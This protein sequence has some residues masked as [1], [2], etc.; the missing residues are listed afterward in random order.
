[1]AVAKP[2]PNHHP[3]ETRLKPPSAKVA[4]QKKSFFWAYC[5][6][7][8]GFLTS[9]VLG[10]WLWQNRA[11]KPGEFLPIAT[12]STVVPQFR[13]D[14][15]AVNLK[16]ASSSQV[17]AIA[18]EMFNQ[19]KLGQG[20]QAVE[21]LLDAKRRQALSQAEL[22]LS[23]ASPTARETPEIKFLWGRLAWQ[24]IQSNKN[25]NKYSVDDA[26]RYWESAVKDRPESLKYRNA[27][28]FA[29]YLEGNLNQAYQVWLEVL[30]AY[31]EGARDWGL[32]TRGTEEKNS[33]LNSSSEVLTAL[34][35][36]GLVRMQQA[37][38]P[39]LS[40]TQRLDLL[41]EAN[42]LR[43]Q[44]MM[45][46]AQSF[47]PSSLSQNWLWPPKAIGDWRSLQKM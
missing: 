43:Q 6:F 14:E 40:P 10:L 25:N 32:E 23:A 8:G 26:R 3:K 2:K 42:K 31:K 21:E 45:Q 36:L 20:Q 47:A 7:P 30:D 44:V 4:K 9:M 19:G 22:A 28:A 17:Q 29:F 18:I 46:D 16:I 38:D 13:S 5:L 34:A 11:P 41:Q 12:P 39:G 33:S 24:S 35:G 15:A 27:L 37:R 1:L